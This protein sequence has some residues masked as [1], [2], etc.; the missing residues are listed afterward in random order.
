MREFPV[1]DA[2]SS[3]EQLRL[4]LKDNE[5]EQYGEAFI[6]EYVYDVI[7]QL[8]RFSTMSVSTCP[9]NSRCLLTESSAVTSKM[10]RSSW[11][12]YWIRCMMS[13]VNQCDPTA[14]KPYRER[15]LHATIL[16]LPLPNLSISQQQMRTDGK[17]LVRSKEQQLLACLAQL[18]QS[19]PSQ[20]SLGAKSDQ[21]YASQACQIL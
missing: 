12:S 1:I 3:V 2:A 16:L 18:L 7:R 4:R 8:P 14:T 21:S 19:L 13:A 10:P 17:K 5:F 6:P 11:G 15:P 9:P 20:R